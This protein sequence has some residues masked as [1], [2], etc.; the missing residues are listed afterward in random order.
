MEEYRIVI[1]KSDRKLYCLPTKFESCDIEEPQTFWD[2][3]DLE[4]IWKSEY[5]YLGQC[6][7][8]IAVEDRN[9][10]IAYFVPEVYEPLN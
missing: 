9:G 6:D 7:N 10:F 4:A 2:D 1:R 8:R 5:K 3:R